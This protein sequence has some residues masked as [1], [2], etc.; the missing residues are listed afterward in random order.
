MFLTGELP[1]G[2]SELTDGLCVVVDGLL[3]DFVFLHQVLCRDLILD[4]KNI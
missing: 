2:L 3:Q 1:D 4:K